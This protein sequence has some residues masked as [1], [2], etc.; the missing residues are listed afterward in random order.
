MPLSSE[1]ADAV[2]EVLARAAQGDYAEPELRS[3]EP[4]LRT[5]AR[6]SQLPVPGTLLI[7]R[8]RSREGQHL[9]LYPFGGRHVH[10]GRASLRAWRRARAAP[11]TFR[12]SINDY[13]LELLSAR[14]VDPAPLVDQRLFGEEGLLEDVLASLNSSELARRR[15]REIARIAG[16]IFTGYPGAPKST[17]QLQASSSLFYE[18]FRKYD[19]GNRLLGQAQAEVLSQELDLRRLAATLAR[20]RACRVEFVELATPSPFALPLMV[21]RFRE[22][23]TTE[24]L[25]DRLARILQ[26]MESAADASLPPR[27]RRRRAAP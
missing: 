4:M 14:P 9:F 6:L 5:Q 16:L 8:Y 12:L 27:P 13:G 3:A 2:L 21:E 22:K 11:N 10:I 25:K 20:L 7:E 18:V 24:K 19:A 26:D 17:R 15:F 1:L 23:L